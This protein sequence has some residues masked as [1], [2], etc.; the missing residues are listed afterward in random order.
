MIEFEYTDTTDD[1]V[2][3]MVELSP[4]FIAEQVR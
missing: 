1:G 4:F 2:N 3:T